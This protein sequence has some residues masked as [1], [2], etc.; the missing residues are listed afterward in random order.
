MTPAALV[1]HLPVRPPAPA[2]RG[3]RGPRG[4]V[5][6]LAVRRGKRSM[7]SSTLKLI[8]A[9]LVQE[10]HWVSRG[11]GGAQRPSMA[12]PAEQGWEGEG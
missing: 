9:T 12:K 4:P 5:A 3:P 10:C 6:W 11:V 2:P 8:S 1:L 7:S